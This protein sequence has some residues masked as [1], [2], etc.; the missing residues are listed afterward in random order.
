MMVDFW[1]LKNTNQFLEINTKVGTD[2]LKVLKFHEVP[3]PQRFFASLGTSWNFKTLR[4]SVPNF[5][6]IPE[7][8]GGG[9]GKAGGQWPCTIRNSLQ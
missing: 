8:W 5:V 6:L 9:G 3:A 2:P 4:G 7:T 1:T